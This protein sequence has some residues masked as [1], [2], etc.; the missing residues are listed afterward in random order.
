M[1]RL[2]CKLTLI[3]MKLSRATIWKTF[4]ILALMVIVFIPGTSHAAGWIDGPMVSVVN[5]LLANISNTVLTLASYA[6]IVSGIFLSVS[7]NITTHIG[8]FFDKMPAL[9]EVWIVIR[10]LS[11]VFIIF[12]LIYSSISTILG[13]NTSQTK[14]LIGKIIVVGLLINF[15]LFFT[16]L[17]IDASNIVSLQFYRAIAPQASLSLDVKNLYNDGGLSNIFMAS[18]KIPTIYQNKSAVSGAVDIPLSIGIATFAGMIMMVTA[19]ISFFAAAIAFSARTAILLFVM[20]LSPLYFAGMIFPEV[21]KKSDKLYELF[22][23]QLLFMPAYLFLMYVALRII[24]SPGFKEIFNQNASGIAPA[25]EGPFGATFISVIIQYVIALFFIN[26]PLIAAIEMGAVGAKWAPDAKSVTGFFGQ[27]TAG[28]GAKWAQGKLATS[29]FAARN[30]NLAVWTNKGLGQVSSG[31]FGG[32]K[33]GY[34]KR[35]KDYVKD[36]TDYVKKIKTSKEESDTYLASTMTEYDRVKANEKRALEYK[37]SEAAKDRTRFERI[38]NDTSR[39]ANLRQIAD[40]QA[41]KMAEQEKALTEQIN[42]MDAERKK[43]AE[44]QEKLSKNL[45]SNQFANALT[46]GPDLGTGKARKE[47]SEAIKK[48][49]NKGKDEKLLDRL[50]TILNKEGGD[51]PAAPSAKP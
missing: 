17:A 46:S 3:N 30:P 7:I 40:K 25:G 16:K 43:E 11:S 20:A 22:M 23:G 42:G 1:P 37:R 45:R 44:K 18:L 48:D 34:E 35:F 51:K 4:S 6:V 15:S 31:S 33:G 36:R 49:L 50:D 27:H 13:I 29:G 21:K 32:T 41:K 38:S 2:S 24:S 39:N 5:T 14:T 9:G 47:A 10:N 28:R 26:I 19:S 8:D 12:I